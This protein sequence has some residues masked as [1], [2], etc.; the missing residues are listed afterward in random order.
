MPIP[1]PPPCFARSII[2][3]FLLPISCILSATSIPKQLIGKPLSVPVLD[4]TGDAKHNQP[5]HIYSKNFSASSG[6]YKRLATVF[7]TRQYASLGD[8]P[9]TKYP[10]D[11][12]F[13][14]TSV[15]PQLG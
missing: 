10:P 7:E 5:C 12:V 11:I 4:S 2:S 6:L 13:L 3:K 9:L 15:S 1:T 14:Y 8:S